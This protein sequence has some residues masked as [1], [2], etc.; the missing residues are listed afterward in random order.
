MTHN[1]NSLIGYT[2]GATDGEIGKVKEFYFDDST[3]TIRYLIIE[4]GNWLNGREVL[5]SPQA[6]LPPDWGNKIFPI[7]LTREKIKNSPA[8]DTQMPV[9]RLQEIKLQ[10]YYVHSDYWIEGF[11]GGGMPLPARS[12]YHDNK[13]LEDQADKSHLRSSAKV[14]G[15]KIKATDGEIGDVVD[16]IIEGNSWKIDFMVVD[17][18]HWFPGKKVLISPKWIKEIDWQ[19]SEVT[20]HA[21]IKQVKVSPEYDAA[22]PITDDHQLHLHNYYR[23]FVTNIE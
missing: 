23:E 20:V 9:S 22:K 4:T 16:F 2:M 13:H 1:L 12:Y 11:Y 10:D 8:I 14:T 17:T 3:W 15:Y 21:S 6:L 7:N 5:I 19:N 18:G